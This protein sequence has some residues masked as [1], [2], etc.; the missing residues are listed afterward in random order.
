MLE[1]VKYIKSIYPDEWLTYGEDF[2][3]EKFDEFGDIQV[4]IKHPNNQDYDLDVV[5]LEERAGIAVI[6]SIEAE[7]LIDLSGF[8]YSFEKDEI[9]NLKKLLWNFFEFSKLN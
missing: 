2:Q 1:I 4:K 7:I 5:V 6:K 8:D 9:D 3:S